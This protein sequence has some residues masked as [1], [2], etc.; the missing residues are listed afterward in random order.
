M[1][2]NGIIIAK[3]DVV[4]NNQDLD[5]LLKR[6]IALSPLAWPLVINIRPENSPAFLSLEAPEQATFLI[7]YRNREDD[8]NFIEITPITYRLLEV[9]SG[10]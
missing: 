8:V 2:G 5:N 3:E 10:T 6:H 4:V 9:Y 7:V 1:G